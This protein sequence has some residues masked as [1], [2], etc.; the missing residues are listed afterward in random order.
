MPFKTYLKYFKLICMHQVRDPC[1]LITPFTLHVLFA[2]L[3]YVFPVVL[4]RS[5]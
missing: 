2:M 1:L 5:G 3:P 4:L